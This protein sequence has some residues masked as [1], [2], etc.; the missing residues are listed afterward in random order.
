MSF[1]GEWEFLRE[2]DLFE[3]TKLAKKVY[4]NFDELPERFIRR[5]FETYWET[6]LIFIQKGEIK[7]FVVYQEWPD[8]LNFIMIYLP[9]SK[10]RNLKVILQGRSLLPDKKIV[11]WDDKKMKARGI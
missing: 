9:F 3:L 8:A 11:W 1:K 5:I 10:T 7:G 2:I 6:T 4:P